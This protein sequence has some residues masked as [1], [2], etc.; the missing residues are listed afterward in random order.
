MLTSHKHKRFIGSVVLGPENGREMPE[1]QPLTLLLDQLHGTR[2]GKPI[3][4]NTGA[5]SEQK[6]LFLQGNGTRFPCSKAQDS[7]GQDYLSPVDYE[8]TFSQECS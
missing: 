1:P 3:I 6:D 4:N 8:E 2:G 5:R 7:P